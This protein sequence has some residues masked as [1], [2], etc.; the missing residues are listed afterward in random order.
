MN[1]P[2]FTPKKFTL[3]SGFRPTPRLV[4]AVDL[5]GQWA[6]PIMIVVVMIAAA[7]FAPA[8]FTSANLKTVSI[9][10]AVLGVVTIGQTLVLLNRSIDMS[11]SAVLALG[12]VIVVQTESGN[13]IAISLVEAVGIAALIGL[14][15]GFL[16]A[17]RHVPPFVATFGMLVFVGG[18][19]LAY[20]K[21]QASG[22]VPNLLRSMSIESIGPIPAALLVWLVVNAIVIF[23]LRY[24]RFGRWVYAVGG[25]PGAAR[26]A[27]V[28]VDWVLI[29]AHVACSVLALLGG[30]LL[31]G[32][33]GYVD[34]R[35]GGDYNMNSIAAAVVGGTTF[36]GGRGNMFG[37]AAGV[38]L[39]IML[40]NLVVVLGLSIHWQYAMQGT[41]LVF[42]TA[43]QGFRQYLLSR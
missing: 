28:N 11:V 3:F 29:S 30:L 12:A 33:I 13:S 27:G 25:N 32:Y 15:N 14:A 19:R 4:R 31:S 39:L 2:T 34:L 36:T 20:T 40:L 35:L 22:T 26:Y 18:A 17:K 8:F 41:V 16:V 38:A 5:A 9:Q 37:T 43:L 21:G 1:N 23:V 7:I 6:A 24:T 10:I 42:A